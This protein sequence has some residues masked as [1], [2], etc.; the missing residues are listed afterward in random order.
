MPIKLAVFDIAGT[1]V[2]DNNNVADAFRQAFT[3]H[4]ID[5]SSINLNH[6]MGIKK[7]VAIAIVLRELEIKSNEKL[8]ESIHDTFIQLMIAHYQHS[9]EVFPLPAVENVFRELQEKKISIALNTGF[10]RNIADVII[11]RL[12]WRKYLD[13]TVASDEV[14]QGRPAPDMIRRLMS[15]TGVKSPAE[16][17]KVGD[18][19]V[20]IKEGRNAG[21]GLVIAVTTGAYR[22]EELLQYEPDFVIDHLSELPSIIQDFA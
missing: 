14:A 11:D 21:C 3:E 19:E 2:N 20:D 17:C 12:G 4:E 13:Q 16:V 7:P 18:T 10:S 6:L 15:A 8:V 9:P 1:T 5:T 22:K